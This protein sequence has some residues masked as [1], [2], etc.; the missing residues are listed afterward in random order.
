MKK[1][2]L[3][4]LFILLSFMTAAPA[5]ETVLDNPAGKPGCTAKEPTAPGREAQCEI[6]LGI[7]PFGTVNWE[8][9]IIQSEGLDAE[10]GFKIDPRPVATPQ[11]GKIALQAGAVEM[12]VSDW[13][14]VTSQRA[15]GSD[16][17]FA[18]YSNT[19]GALVVPENSGIK[20][21]AD[22]KGKRLGIAGGGLDK[23]WLLLRGLAQKQFQLDLDREVE[24]VFGA[25]PLLN[26]QMRQG[27][28]DA[29]INFWHYA[30]Q[31]EAKGYRQLLDSRDIL[32]GLGIER[33]VPALGYVFGE[34]WAE[35]NRPAVE[36]FLKASRLAKDL[37]CESDPAW[38][39]ILP[40]TQTDDPAVQAM[41]R[42]RYCDGRI[43]HWG[44][45][46]KQAAGEIFALL[47]QLGGVPLTGKSDTLQNG[48][49]WPYP[50][51]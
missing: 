43:K 34:R 2:A 32:K 51:R 8:I 21:V 12:I 9:S 7:L 20:T 17:T 4:L 18:P 1:R 49:F 44:D 41:L 50:S 13:L 37:L 6:I 45:E 19:A 27:N 30:A 39:K 28:L 10:N 46:E 40:L 42:Q 22:L 47:R 29:L 35:K 16:L 36:G 25:P 24:K 26:E 38:R 15:A 14:W 5:E 3:P 33:E 23:N 11:A 48:T 31:L